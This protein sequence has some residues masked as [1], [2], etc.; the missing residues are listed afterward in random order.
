MNEAN[1]YT[2]IIEGCLI[3]LLIFT[4]LALGTVQPRSIFI[5]RIVVVI[6]L[7]SWLLKILSQPTAPNQPKESDKPTNAKLR[8]LDF[9]ILAFLGV[10]TFSTFVVSPYKHKSL[11][12][13]ANLTTY[14]ALYFFIVNN[15]KSESQI[16][17]LVGTILIASTISGIYGILQYLN[18]IN[19]LPY[20]SN[21]RVSSTYYG[22]SH[23]AG[24]LI[25]VTPLAISRFLFS[26]SLWKTF[27]FGALS[28]L[29]ITNLALSFSITNL[30]FVI[31][32]ISL[33][34]V[35]IYFREHKIIMKR[36]LAGAIG[37]FC[38]YLF[39]L[40]GSPFMLYFSSH[41]KLGK[42]VS[43][44]QLGIN[45]RVN[46]WKFGLPV[47][48][49]RPY[50][51]WGLGLFSDIF[52]KYRPASRT[53]F[54]NYAHS[55]YLQIASDMGIIGLGV[56]LVVIGIIVKE[57]ISTLKQT[58]RE[59]SNQGIAIGIIVALFAAIVRSFID[60]NLFIL[61]SLSIYF[62]TL[63]GLLIVTKKTERAKS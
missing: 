19:F 52:S 20:E 61:Q 18:M 36:L 48:L 57:F 33:F 47:F 46:I 60:C 39:M 25:M 15:I 4:P 50:A 42:L 37:F 21:I 8:T 13:F 9:A 38:L 29:L 59:R 1:R 43:S 54:L 34:L 40:T 28:A 53:N 49:D 7:T 35:I 22:A 55:D 45:D 31:S 63:I 16:K 62:F 6:A 58:K 23:Y 10:A 24:F 56:Y 17:K 44:L 30:A 2:K 3:F 12:W 14:T 41:I 32:M 11:N 51:G 27:T 26:K 5:M